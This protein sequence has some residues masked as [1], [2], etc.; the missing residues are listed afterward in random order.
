VATGLG[1]RGLVWAPLCAEIFVSQLHD[2]PL[3]VERDLVEAVAPQRFF[4]S[5][6]TS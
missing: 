3:P 4:R 2:E 1:A 6:A 5:A